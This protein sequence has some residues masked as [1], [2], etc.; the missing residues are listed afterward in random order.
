[1]THHTISSTI[2]PIPEWALKKVKSPQEVDKFECYVPE[3][4]SYP[5]WV[6]L[7][8]IVGTSTDHLTKGSWVDMRKALLKK[9]SD[10]QYVE[11]GKTNLDHS[12]A[13]SYQPS[14]SALRR[15]VITVR[16]YGEEY[17]LL[18]S[19]NHRIC[20]AKFA[21]VHSLRVQLERCFYEG[22]AQ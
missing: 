9:N 19:G 5:T 8:K 4:R 14:H 18:E 1:M 21:C 20:H 13:S 12:E 2:D 10:E 7:E 11:W 3:G 6:E 15:D 17:F 16:Q 22:V